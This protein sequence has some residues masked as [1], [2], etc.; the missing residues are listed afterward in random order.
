MSQENNLDAA[1]IEI[2]GDIKNLNSAIATALAER[3]TMTS[4]TTTTKDNLVNAIN[5]LNTAIGSLSGFTDADADARVQAAKGDPN[6]P[7]TTQWTSTQDLLDQLAAL[8]DEIMGPDV[9]AALDTLKELGTELG[10]QDSAISN[11]LTAQ[12]KRVAVDQAQTFT[13]AEKLQACQNLGIGNPEADYLTTY[14]NERD[15]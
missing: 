4:L 3:G 13:A 12:A 10:D 6:T 2:G 5:E 1:F 11:I 8:K 9:S 15:S 14:T 7:S